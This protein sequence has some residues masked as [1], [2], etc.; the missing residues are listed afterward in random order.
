VLNAG[1]NCYSKI[2]GVAPKSDV[3]I[4][5]A[6]LKPHLMERDQD[7]AAQGDS[8]EESSTDDRVGK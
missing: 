4:K 5:L 1:L 8:H 2:E 6:T 7:L 3:L